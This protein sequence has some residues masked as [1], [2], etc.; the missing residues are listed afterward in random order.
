MLRKIQVLHSIFHEI[1][2]LGKFFEA[3]LWPHSKDTLEGDVKSP[4]EWQELGDYWHDGIHHS[5]KYIRITDP[6]K[7]QERSVL[8]LS[9]T[10]I[11]LDKQECLH[12]E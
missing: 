12:L 10:W 3:P 1:W 2:A 9:D 11:S 7:F 5:G 8:K 4:R 6:F